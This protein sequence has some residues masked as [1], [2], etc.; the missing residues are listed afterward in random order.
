MRR[1]LVVAL[2]WLA[3]TV[4]QAQPA[5]RNVAVRVADVA[6]DRAYVSPGA[7]G[8]LHVGAQITIARASYRVV[9]VTASY[10]VVE[11]GERALAVGARGRA[12]VRRVREDGTPEP[13]PEPPPVESFRGQWPTAVHP[14]TTQEVAHVPLGGQLGHARQLIVDVSA[15]GY[16]FVPL[17][18]GGD[19]IGRGELR[20]R[21][22]AQP[23]TDL[24]LTLDA[25]AAVQLWVG[26]TL[27]TGPGAASRPNLRVRELQIAY[28]QQE[29][30]YAALG[31]MRYAASTLGQLDGLRVQTPALGPLTLAGFGGFVPDPRNGQPA[32][33]VGRFG[34]EATVRDL[35]SELR[36]VVSVVAHGSVYDGQIDERRISGA[37]HLYPG[38]S[39][40]GGYVEVSAFDADNPWDLPEV[41]VTA[42]SLD[43]TLRF[44]W[45][46]V[47]ARASMR[48]PERSKW[49]AALYPTS[50]LCTP[51]PN[52]TGAEDLCSGFLDMRILGNLDV[53]IE[54][55]DVAL[56]GGATLIHTGT[57]GQLDQVAA[58]LAF[59][60]VRILDYGHLDVSAT[61]SSGYFLETLALRATVG[62][63]AIPEVLDISLRY[64]PALSQYVA[65][66]DPFVEHLFGGRV[67]VRPI[68][69]LDI[70]LDA[71]GMMGRQVDA[72]LIQ[73]ATAWHGAF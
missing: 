57:D 25:D 52:P 45:F 24:P 50:F 2:V 61:A 17:R 34:L 7:E 8:G 49:L 20:A 69:E 37:F 23:W 5:T 68:P 9:A 19:P 22:H 56:T 30:F 42:A 67:L 43:T 3:A 41:V 66:I 1:S 14:A 35:E 47:G 21:V 29:D 51:V 53:G 62:V 15:R 12:R 48:M 10:A 44:D 18:G 54:V 63:S 16:A 72:F 11:R 46:R 27:D 70:V 39:H 28:G 33:D 65:D 71:D 13:L 26:D 36:P 58:F 31:R 55:D 60:A 4:A 73:L 59:R 32:F 38:E 6:G 40:I 64:R